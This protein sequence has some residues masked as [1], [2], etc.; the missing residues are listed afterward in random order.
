MAT[1]KDISELLR[2]HGFEATANEVLDVLWY[3]HQQVEHQTIESSEPDP[4]VTHERSDGESSLPDPVP[5]A[6]EGTLDLDS[7]ELPVPSEAGIKEQ[8]TEPAASLPPGNF[9]DS[10][11]DNGGE[12]GIGARRGE[13][14]AGRALFDVEA[15]AKSLLPLTERSWAYRRGSMDIDAM[16]D[17]YC[18][19]GRVWEVLPHRR[20]EVPCQVVLVREG[21]PSSSFW[22]P[23]LEEFA[24]LLQRQMQLPVT[25]WELDFGGGVP[26][27]SHPG[28]RV[29][30]PISTLLNP[31]KSQLVIVLSDG[32][33]AAWRQGLMPLVLHRW[34]RVH[35]TTLL[36]PYAKHLLDRSE[37]GKRIQRGYQGHA[38]LSDWGGAEWAGGKASQ[39]RKTPVFLLTLDGPTMRNW[40]GTMRGET[41]SVCAAATF[42]LGRH[43]SMAPS[44]AGGEP[45]AV[46]GDALLAAFLRTAAPLTRELARLLA[47]VPLFPP[48][49]RLV[50]TL[51]LPESRHVHL[52]EFFYSGLIYRSSD[53]D[54]DLE[55][56]KVLYQFRPVLPGQRELREQLLDGGEPRTTWEVISTVT[57]WAAVHL[58]DAQKFEALIVGQSEQGGTA[59]IPNHLLPF[60]QSFGQALKR[61]RHRELGSQLVALGNRSSEVTEPPIEEELRP[62]R[63]NHLGMTLVECPPGTFTMGSP[64]YEDGREPLAN[65]GYE[66]QHEVT[67]TEPFWIC[68]TPV[69]Q[70]HWRQLM[71]TT[72]RDQRSENSVSLEYG[73]IAGE[74]EDRPMYFVTWLECLTFCDRLTAEARQRGDIGQDEAYCLPTE[75]Q[76]EYAC[77]AGTSG[78]FAGDDLEALGWY[79][80]N[81]ASTTHDVAR[82]L[83][84]PWGLYDV[85]G[86]VYEWCADYFVGDLGTDP[87]EDPLTLQSSEFR[88]I[89]GGAWTR[90]A[91]SCRSARRAGH[92]YPPQGRY[93]HIGFR[94]V[95][96]RQAQRDKLNEVTKPRLPVTLITRMEG[97]PDRED[98]RD[99]HKLTVSEAGFSMLDIYGARLHGIR[100][101][102]IR[103]FADEVNVS[104]EIGTLF[105]DAPISAMPRRLFRGFTGDPSS[106]MLVDFKR[107]FEK[108]IL[109]NRSV[110]HASKWVVDLHV[111]PDPVPH[112]YLEI[113]E[114]LIA[115][116]GQ[117]N[118]VSEVLLCGCP[119]TPADQRKPRFVRVPA[120]TFLMGSPESEEGRYSNETQ[121]QVTIRRDFEIAE[122]PVTQA[123]YQAVMGTNPSFSTESGLDAPVEQVS[124]EDAKAYCTK[125]TDNDEEGW[126][127]SLPTEA[128]WE[129]ACRGGTAGP[130][131]VEGDSL[132]DLGWFKQNSGSKTHPVK[133]KRPNALGI[134][135]AHGNVLEW[136]ADWF[137]D[138]LGSEAVTDPEGPEEGGYRVLRGGSWFNGARL[139]RSAG[140]YRFDPGNRDG[141]IGFRPVR[142][143]IAEGTEQE[144]VAQPETKA[145]ARSQEWVAKDMEGPIEGMRMLYL[146]GGTYTMGEGDSA[147]EVTLTQDFYIAETQVTQ[148]QYQAVMG[149]NPSHFTGLGPEAPVETVNWDDAKAFCAKLNEAGVA[150]EGWHYVLPTEAQWEY[151]CRS[152]TKT[153][154]SWGD[155]WEKGRANVAN[156]SHS[157]DQRAY[158]ESRGLP[159]EST[160]PVKTFAP[161]P[162]GLFDAHGNVWE[163]CADWFT[164]DLG[165]EAVTDPVGQERGAYCVLRGGCWYFNAQYC[166]SADRLRDDPG[167]R[168]SDI[169]FRPV[170]TRKE[171]AEGTELESVAQPET[172]AG[173]RSAEDIAADFTNS[174]GM[175]MLC[176]PPGTFTM[177]SPADEVGREQGAAK[178][179]Q[180]QVR[181]TKPFWIAKKPV[182]QK[183]WRA[184][185]GTSA[186]DQKALENTFGEV[187]GTGE[188][189]P[190]YFVNWEEAL[191]FCD[192]LTQRER[193]D[194]QI[195][196]EQAYTLPTES[197]W[198]YACRAGKTG[199]YAGDSLYEM[200][201][202]S[203]NSQGSTQPVGQ[204]SE[205]AWG[206][207]DMHGNV[208]EWCTDWFTEDLGAQ[209]LVDPQGPDDGDYRVLRGGSWDNT[210]QVCRSAFRSRNDPE[211]RSG[212]IGFRPVLTSQEAR[213]KLGELPGE[214]EAAAQPEPQARKAGDRRSGPA[215]MAFVWIPPGTFTVGSPPDEEG[216]E[217]W[218]AKETQHEVTLTLGFEIMESPVTQAQWKAVMGN[219]PSYFTP[220]L[221]RGNLPVEQVSWEDAQSFCSKLSELDLEYAYRLPTEAEWEYAC[222]A[223]T[224]GPF[225]IDGARLADL[226]WY[227]ENS[228][229]KTHPVKEKKPNIWGVYDAHGNVW[230]WCA[231]WF[232]KDLG[233]EVAVNPVG[234]EN[235]KYRVVRGGSWSNNAQG[236]RS[237]IRYWDDPGYRN[238]II[239]FRPGR[240]KKQ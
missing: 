141:Y 91:R 147:H 114:E 225:N 158:F 116:Q 146:G 154:Y 43:S 57:R 25:Q 29:S 15:L 223:G 75:A 125:L 30:K 5:E 161:N 28:G 139:C 157:S 97:S 180:H 156:S 208:W 106:R 77:R 214:P 184:I 213:A 226:G 19:N 115:E 52:A 1:L 10:T 110:I 191:Q 61:T 235:G 49:M 42:S 149:S 204:K 123:Q 228:G 153:T 166:R 171:E 237:A 21:S 109:L 193:Q 138:D 185:M 210:A 20:R 187:T 117:M 56:A 137:A 108:F 118:G 12:A 145:G 14:F 201:W 124:W 112:G 70:K 165:S 58:E 148:G 186:Q 4:P 100:T 174:L 90:R 85:H 205:N 234:P 67:L 98:V 76:W 80:D 121:H 96:S 232:V 71:G 164:E 169:G 36:L 101:D 89:R 59:T 229:G 215:G 103:N 7:I 87:V 53:R 119:E 218:E 151:A 95:L 134:Y 111:S 34:A 227:S 129:F 155:D 159:T 212:P 132:E 66:T 200:G 211:N 172:E 74:G 72:I 2:Q 221:S 99:W 230:E 206:L 239:G 209:P 173:T 197:Q 177:G 144:S 26:A 93:N 37:A 22:S 63:N 81:S 82:K 135:D 222:R 188:D 142:R 104:D 86:N 150:P 41:G 178:E 192:L 46:D 133:Q 168:S 216:R 9:L 8:G 163:W 199:P 62:T 167:D 220:L 170:L 143:K 102:V 23:L 236:C 176:L 233:S 130:F 224:F 18:R 55:A 231:D 73:G 105:P 38:R 195:S 190:M 13:I 16:I 182:T 202:N 27:I 194:R 45:P 48:V 127:Y 136:C 92:D 152:G 196:D 11:E 120:G 50:Q 24:G 203:Q 64:E 207:Q 78:S 54:S 217:P 79:L 88:V 33:S 3:H 181:L 69:T 126:G 6:I 162:W 219:N 183:A 31:G 113:V 39:L 94:P 140:R 65:A 189:H 107:E 35:P 122:T 238:G 175:D 198:E 179:T 60:A 84:N 128:E 17:R 51:F 131:N 32:G 44:T 47:V 40:A 160:M 83:P 240:Q 68:T